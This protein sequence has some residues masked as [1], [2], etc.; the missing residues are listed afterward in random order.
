MTCKTELRVI[1]D[2]EISCTQWTAS[3]SL[4]MQSMLLG[5]L[6]DYCLSFVMGNW[7]FKGLMYIIERAEPL[8]LEKLIKAC[9]YSVKV[10]NVQVTERS[11]DD[12]F[13]GDISLLYETFSFVLQTNFK[14]FF[15]EGLTEKDQNPSQ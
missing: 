13:S 9:C 14:D 7:D 10:D 12:I 6:G 2:K 8:R 4:E 3:K 11:F 1:K 15:I 5:T